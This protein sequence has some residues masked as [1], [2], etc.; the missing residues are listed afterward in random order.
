MSGSEAGIVLTLLE[1]KIV[2]RFLDAGARS[3]ATSKSLVEIGA[4]DNLIFRR[5]HRRSVIVEGDSGKWFVDELAWA[6]LRRQ[7]RIIVATI[8][9]FAATAAAIIYFL[10]R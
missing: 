9:L 8:V 2:R 6:K 4:N 3:R 10:F 5:L 1:R 7:R